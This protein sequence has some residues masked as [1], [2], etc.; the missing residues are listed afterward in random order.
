M[1][2]SVGQH[3]EQTPGV[4]TGEADEY[5]YWILDVASPKVA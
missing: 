4:G 1:V 2:F 3:W 5:A